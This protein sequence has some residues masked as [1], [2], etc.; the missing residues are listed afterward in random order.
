M[1]TATVIFFL[2]YD[3]VSQET[4]EAPIYCRITVDGKRSDMS[5][6][7]SVHP[8]RW[9]D[10]NQLRKAKKQEDRELNFYME[11]I[12][13]KI[14]EIERELLDQKIQITSENIKNFCSGNTQK[15]K[16]LIKIFDLHNARFKELVDRDEKANG[17]LDRYKQTLKHVQAFLKR[18]Y[19]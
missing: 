11:S 5:I 1:K 16:S 19:T 2:R 9:A 10:T 17:T 3:K 8:Q 12:K 13:S 7:R 14:K 18:Q 15:S 6:N 4:G